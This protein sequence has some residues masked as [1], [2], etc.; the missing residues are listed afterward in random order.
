MTNQNMVKHHVKLVLMGENYLLGSTY[1]PLSLMTFENRLLALKRKLG[2][3]RGK[4][5]AAVL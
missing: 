2:Q 4:Q 1:I 3:K 5:K